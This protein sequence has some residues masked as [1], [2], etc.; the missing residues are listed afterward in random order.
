MQVIANHTNQHN[1]QSLAWSSTMTGPTSECHQ[2]V[3]WAVYVIPENWWKSSV[4]GHLG[5][6]R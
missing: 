1:L 3:S 5:K 6:V 4:L 2:M